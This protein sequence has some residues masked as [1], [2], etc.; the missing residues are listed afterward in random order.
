MKEGGVADDEEL[1]RSAG[2]G[3]SFKG[4][5]EEVAGGIPNG[6]GAPVVCELYATSAWGVISSVRCGGLGGPRHTVDLDT[7]QMALQW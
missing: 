5:C 2:E 7:S 1:E 6:G 4:C 3:A